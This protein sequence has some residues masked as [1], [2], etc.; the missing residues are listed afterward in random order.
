MADKAFGLSPQ[1]PI[2][3]VAAKKWQEQA[4]RPSPKTLQ[5][6]GKAVLSQE[7]ARRRWSGAFPGLV[8]AGPAATPEISLDQ[9]PRAAAEPR[10]IDL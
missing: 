8:L 2:N 1:R 6:S 7:L 4:K 3:A 9:E 5:K 10:A